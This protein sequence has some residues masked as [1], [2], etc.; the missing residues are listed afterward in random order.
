MRRKC[1]GL[2]TTPEHWQEIILEQKKSKERKAI[3][4]QIRKS[5]QEAQRQV[6]KLTTIEDVHRHKGRMMEFYFSLA[7]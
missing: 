4:K 1:K 5:A 3:K 6:R 2:G 7:G